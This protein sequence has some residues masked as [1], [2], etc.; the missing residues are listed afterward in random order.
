MVNEKNYYSE[1]INE[2]IINKDNEILTLI[3]SN[4]SKLVLNFIISING[5]PINLN[6]EDVNVNNVNINQNLNFSGNK[7]S[8][9]AFNNLKQHQFSKE[10]YRKPT[11]TI[12]YSLFYGL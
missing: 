10:L 1:I 11:T 2:S 8:Q 9:Q 7:N 5:D 6:L 12:N 3:F 4:I